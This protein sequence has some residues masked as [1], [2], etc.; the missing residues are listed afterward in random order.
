VKR[1][2]RNFNSGPDFLNAEIIIN[3]IKWI[4]N[5]E[6]HLNSSL[7]YSHKHH[8]D[9]SYNNVVLHVVFDEDK[10]CFNSEGFEIPCLELRS[11]VSK[12][13]L[14]H[15]SDL[16]NSLNFIPC[17]DS[18]QDVNINSIQ[19]AISMGVESRLERM[20]K[21]IEMDLSEN[22]GNWQEVFYS[23]LIRGFGFKT[24]SD[25][26]RDLSKILPVKLLL[27]HRDN[28]F[29]L[30]SLLFGQAGLLESKVQDNYILKLKKE[31]R[32][33][34]RK[35]NLAPM[36]IV[37]WRFMRMRPANFPTIRLAQIAALFYN[38]GNL[39]RDIPSCENAGDMRNLFLVSASEYWNTHFRFGEL[40]ASKTKS[41]GT[42]SIDVLIIN[43]V[44]PFLFTFGKIR[45]IERVSHLAL[46]ILKELK[47]EYNRVIKEWKEMGVACKS[48]YESQGMLELSKKYCNFGKC[49]SCHIGKEILRE[50]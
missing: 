10:D 27:Q 32:F 37:N 48:A 43:S 4:G 14:T 6:I 35:Y 47:G 2:Y 26:M 15:Y 41:I 36:S 13:L 44:I 33:L 9:P 30:E 1:G 28:L 12:N 31:Y 21:E 24:N 19:L 22:R 34:A 5:V 16:R 45:R 46:N 38:K 7:W 3:G 25:A 40:S 18:I 42:S 29:Q 49:A 17:S 11:R 50:K 23:L 20:S 8:R 39:W